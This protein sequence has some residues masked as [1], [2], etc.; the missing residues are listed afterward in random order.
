[1]KFVYPAVFTK[2][3][4]GA[5]SVTFP[6]LQGA[7]TCA[8]TLEEAFDMAVDCLGLVLYDMQEENEDF[9]SPSK[10]TAFQNTENEF[11]NLIKIDMQ[12]YRKRVDAKPVKKTVYI[13]KELNDK[14]TELDI[15]FSLVLRKAL[16][17]EVQLVH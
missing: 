13:P 14:A 11:A 17:K 7:H 10:L 9:P 6:D 3:L 5:Y 15:N 1:M 2:E 4:N 8:N 12:E 16:A